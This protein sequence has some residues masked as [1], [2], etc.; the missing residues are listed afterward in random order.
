[1][2]TSAYVNEYCIKSHSCV[3]TIACLSFLARGPRFV[4]VHV[5]A[6]GIC[7]FLVFQH[8]SS[9][10]KYTMS[11]S[12]SLYI[13][14]CCYDNDKTEIVGYMFSGNACMFVIKSE[15]ILYP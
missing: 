12:S 8:S 10:L 6:V 2:V 9:P 15:T 4:H 13:Y 3:I 7:L 11:C 5:S 1:M 14:T